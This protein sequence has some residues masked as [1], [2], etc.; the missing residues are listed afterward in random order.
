MLTLPDGQRVPCLVEQRAL[1]RED[2]RL[3]GN[4]YL[5]RDSAS[6]VYVRV[7]PDSIDAAAIALL[8]R[9]IS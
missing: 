1:I 7:D 4:V 6:G 5:I 9:R 2:V 8:A 3:T